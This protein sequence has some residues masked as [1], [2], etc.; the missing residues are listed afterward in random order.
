MLRARPG[1]AKVSK[2]KKVMKLRE[3]RLFLLSAENEI[4]SV[5]VLQQSILEV[6]FKAH[7]LGQA[8]VPLFTRITTPPPPPSTLCCLGCRS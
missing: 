3:H 1:L 7:L 2:G 4:G 8:E 6:V 5:L